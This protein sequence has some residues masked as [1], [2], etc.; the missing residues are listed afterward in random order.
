MSIVVH[1][2]KGILYSNE[3]EQTGTFI[4]WVNVTNIA[5][6]YN[7]DMPDTEECI[8]SSPLIQFKN[9]QNESVELESWEYLPL[10]EE[11]V[12]G[13]SYRVFCWGEGGTCCLLFLTWELVAM[14]HFLIF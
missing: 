9:Q 4:T 14:Y 1:T 2:H 11:V 3:Y 13:R 6:N 12:T 5:L 10:E 8:S 7:D